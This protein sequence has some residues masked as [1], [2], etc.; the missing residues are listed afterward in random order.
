MKLF[1]SR[2][3]LDTI[4]TLEYL[5]WCLMSIMLTKAVVEIFYGRLIESKPDWE[6]EVAHANIAHRLFRA[7]PLLD[8]FDNSTLVF[9]FQVFPCNCF[10][11]RRT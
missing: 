10:K 1:T 3:R 7:L 6:R 8:F 11:R 2:R 4:Q 5:W 9:H